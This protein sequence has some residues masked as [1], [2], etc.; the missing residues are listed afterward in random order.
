M[1]L[2]G[3]DFM[4]PWTFSYIRMLSGKFRRKPYFVNNQ[5]DWSG[6]VDAKLMNFFNSSF[7]FTVSQNIFQ[8]GLYQLDAIY[9]N[10]SS[11]MVV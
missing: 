2:T 4:V 8:H 3:N 5:F 1:H 7:L 9:T 11:S 6:P 10:I